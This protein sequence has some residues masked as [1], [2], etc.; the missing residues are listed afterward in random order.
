M[1]HQKDALIG[2]LLVFCFPVAMAQNAFAQPANENS[3]KLVSK[4]GLQKLGKVI[5]GY[6][7]NNLAVGA[8][9]LAIQNGK[10][11][12]HKSFGLADRDSKRK[13]TNDMVCNIRSMTKPLTSAAAQILIDRKQ[14]EL[15]VPVAKYLKSFDNKKSKSI[16]VRQVLT[17]RSGMPLTNIA[18]LDQYKSLEEQ[19]AAGGKSGPQFEPDSKFWYSDLGT[20]VVGRLVA[21]VSGK[22]LHEFVQSELLEPIGMKSSFYGIDIKDQRLA[23]AASP[24]M[25]GGENGWTQFWKPGS[26]PLY[27]FAWGSQTIYSTTSDYARFLN[28]LMSQGR[29][30]EKQVLSKEAV[31]RMMEPVSKAKGM[32]SDTDAPTGFSGLESWYGQMMVTY[33]PIGK[34]KKTPVA[35]GHSGSD[36]TIAWAWPDRDLIMLYFTQSRGGFTPIRIEE[37]IDR[38]I[39]H[40]DSATGEIVPDSLK[41]FVGTYIANHAQFDNE[42]FTVRTSNGKLVLDV[43]SQLAFVLQSPDKDG[44]R[45]FKIAP[46]VQVSFDRDKQNKVIGLTMYQGGNQYKVPRKGTAAARKQAEMKLAAKKEKA[47]RLAQEQLKEAWVG[48][49]DLGAIKPVMQFRIVTQKSGETT[50]YFDSVTE[51]QTGFKAT[52]SIENRELKF[53]VAKI[54]LSYRGKLNEAGTKAEGIWKQ[55]GR[56][57]P[58]SLSKRD[59]AVK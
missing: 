25:R 45:A 42:E 5:N 15:D 24:Y 3:E 1:T 55:G 52:W 14:L 56:E 33:H 22:H 18:S 20:D 34:E 31:M 57:F 8:E 48:E 44:K 9:F 29:V 6:I 26:K 51:G 32:G 53:D 47:E 39:L 17:H 59:K 46:Q 50:A 4:T 36:G 23:K 21:K 2:L 12:Y 28:M 30:G 27:N 49:L 54:K 38:L 13:W 35:F 43:P 7:E 11:L 10:V 19:V 58:L 40:S 37:A 16:T 41:P